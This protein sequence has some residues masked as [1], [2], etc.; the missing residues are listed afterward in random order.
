MSVYNELRD[1]MIRAWRDAGNN[2]HPTDAAQKINGALDGFRQP[3]EDLSGIVAKQRAG[4]YPGTDAFKNAAG[5]TLR[6]LDADLDVL[7]AAVASAARADSGKVARVIVDQSAA[8]R[9]AKIQQGADAEMA[10]QMA[11]LIEQARA[12]V[13][14]AGE[15]APPGGGTLDRLSPADVAALTE[16]IQARAAPKEDKIVA[17]QLARIGGQIDPG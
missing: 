5:D 9:Q 1:R 4:L 16:E 3:F 7:K 11:R 17:A 14:A 15:I 8:V 2:F 13:K 6:V 12:D 10:G